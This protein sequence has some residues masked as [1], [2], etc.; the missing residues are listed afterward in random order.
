MK[1]CSFCG[2]TNKVCNTEIGLLCDKHYLQYKRHGKL[3]C[4]TKYDYNE[5]KVKDGYATIKLYDSNANP[6]AET[7]IDIDDV[8]KVISY[9]WCLD[10][11]NY[12]KN[13]KQEYLH[14]VI[15]GEHTLFIDHINGNTLDNRKSNLR[16]C[17]NADN[18]KNRVKLP[19][20]NTSG[21]IGIYFRKDRNKWCA[22][23]KSNGI[24]YRFGSFDTKEE[25]I[26]ARL[27]G[28]LAYFG[29]YK[30]KVL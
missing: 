16:V 3:L 13:S 17:S 28:E 1:K 24:T 9:K 4:R 12:V 10:K 22:E 18:L 7:I 8:S 23:L 5:I 20:N 30:S 26:E 2:S 15:M 14:R 27:K 11:N 21:V 29:E 19:K 25:A 6:I